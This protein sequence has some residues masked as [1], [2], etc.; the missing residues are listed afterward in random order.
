MGLLGPARWAWEEG[1]NDLVWGEWMEWIDDGQWEGTRE[2]WKVEG[3][4]GWDGM[5]WG[6]LDLKGK[7]GVTKR[8]AIFSSRC[9][10][11]DCG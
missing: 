4:M 5:G 6:E 11:S 1:G 7:R 9:S 3:W 10:G 8:E 2:R